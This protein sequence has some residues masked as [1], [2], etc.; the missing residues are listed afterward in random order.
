MQTTEPIKR[1]QLSLPVCTGQW[2]F[3]QKLRNKVNNLQQN[4]TKTTFLISKCLGQRQTSTMFNI[5]WWLATVV[6]QKVSN[7]FQQEILAKLVQ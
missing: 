4:H 2:A 5:I 1:P 6:G 3:Q 7:N